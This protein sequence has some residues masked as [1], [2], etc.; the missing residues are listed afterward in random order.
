MIDDSNRKIYP[1]TQVADEL[2]ITPKALVEFALKF[3]FSLFIEVP[4]NTEIYLGG[5]ALSQQPT[6]FLEAAMLHQAR[7]HNEKIKVSQDIVYLCI[8][9]S[10]CE[11]IL[12]KGNIGKSTFDTVSMFK[13]GTGA[14]R[15][16]PN[17]YVM[18]FVTN[19]YKTIYIDG[20]FQTFLKSNQSTERSIDIRYENMLIGIEDLQTIKHSLQDTEPV[21]GKF[22]KGDWTSVKLA[23]LNE[24]STYFFSSPNENLTRSET[25]A[26]IE[27]WLRERWGNTAGVIL[28]NE[29][30][31]A[32]IQD[33]TDPEIKISNHILSI[34]NS[35]TSKTLTIINEAA[36]QHAKK[37]KYNQQLLTILETNYKFIGRLTKAAATIIRLD[38]A[39]KI[40][41]IPHVKI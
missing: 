19:K 11:L 32:I 18:N 12:E 17:E 21:Y 27:I 40:K 36:F 29:A 7:S 22:V 33:K 34:C 2:G 35:Y 20:F 23:Q 16:T 3:K 14:I 31:K 25:I 30:A 26:K 13:K 5:T 15:L 24:A 10:D 37:T 4:T 9:A 39:K 6:T 8:D 1:A 28:V 38:A 41:P